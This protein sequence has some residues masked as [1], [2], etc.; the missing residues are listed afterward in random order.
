M[1]RIF[2]L[3]GHPAASSLS[4]QMALAYAEAARQAGH[5]VRVM[6]LHEMAFDADFGVAGYRQAKPLEPVLEEFLGHL[7]W[8]GHL[9]LCTPM[10]WGG[11]PARLKGLIDRSLLPGRAFD[12]RQ[13]KYGLPAPLLAGRT[14]RVLMTSDTPG[15]FFRLAYRSALVVQLRRQILGFVGFKPSRFTHFSPASEPKP[16]QVARWLAE[17]TR[18][19]ARGA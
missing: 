7:Q 11:L 17:V 3:D 4:R 9:V 18:L 5:E 19:G 12:T 2:I 14:A 15:W 16:G 1:A 10:W 13:A 6:H 8:C